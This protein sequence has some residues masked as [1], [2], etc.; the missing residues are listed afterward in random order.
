MP[1][2]KRDKEKQRA[3]DEAINLLCAAS[4]IRDGKGSNICI[5]QATKILVDFISCLPDT[6]AILYS[7]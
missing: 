1:D 7:A 2:T 5:M 4:E 3:I 6:N